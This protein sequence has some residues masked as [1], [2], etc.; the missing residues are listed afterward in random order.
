[1]S[2]FPEINRPE[3]GF[4][5]SR[6]LPPRQPATE[7][8]MVVSQILFALSNSHHNRHMFRDKQ[9]GYATN[10]QVSV[11]LYLIEAF[12]K[13]ADYL[14]IDIEEVVRE[15]FYDL[16]SGMKHKAARIRWKLY[17][18]YL[19]E[20]DLRYNCEIC[21]GVLTH[22]RIPWSLT[23]K[24]SNLYSN[25]LPNQGTPEHAAMIKRSDRWGFCVPGYLENRAANFKWGLDYEA[26]GIPRSESHWPLIKRLEERYGPLHDIYDG[27]I[28]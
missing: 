8:E 9:H 1:M 5:L 15:M 25:K 24:Q 11:A 18:R 28:E 2:R 7:I 10:N 6:S 12:C 26:A 14:N 16:G 17:K 13:P 21:F 3:E 22:C 20:K 19:P 23:R 27:P 4:K